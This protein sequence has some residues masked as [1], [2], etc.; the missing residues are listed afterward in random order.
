M[1]EEVLWVGIDVQRTA[2]EMLIIGLGTEAKALG[3]HVQLGPV[4]GPL[5]KIPEVRGIFD[6]LEDEAK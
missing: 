3:V 5:G 1:Q 2:E 6:D 4:G